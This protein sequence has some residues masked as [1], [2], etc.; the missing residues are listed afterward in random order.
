MTMFMICR[1]AM[2]SSSVTVSDLR[3]DSDDM[4]GT[5]REAIVNEHEIAPDTIVLIRPQTLP[6]TT[7]GKIQRNLTRRLWFE[8]SLQLL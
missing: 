3:I 4:I 5:I 1:I 8:G 7:S 6:R 2:L